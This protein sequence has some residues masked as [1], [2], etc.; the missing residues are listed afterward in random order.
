MYRRKEEM[1]EHNCGKKAVSGWQNTQ[2]MHKIWSVAH[3][4]T[5]RGEK[6]CLDVEYRGKPG[7]GKGKGLLGIDAFSSEEE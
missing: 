5:W 4:E 1:Q 2:C 6:Q 7:N 3:V